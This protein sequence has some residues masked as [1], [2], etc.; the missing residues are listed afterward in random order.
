[1]MKD[2]FIAGIGWIASGFVAFIVY[3]VI[4][5]SRACSCPMIPANATPEEVASICHCA[6][7]PYGLLVVG[8]VAIIVG[9]A[10]LIFNEPLGRAAMRIKRR[11]G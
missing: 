10:I 7:T 4:G 3:W 8:T 1:M 5:Q 11:K 6:G 2:I 9:I